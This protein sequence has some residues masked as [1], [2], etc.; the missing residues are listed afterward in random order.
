[1]TTAQRNRDLAEQQRSRDDVVRAAGRL[2]AERGFHGTSMRHLGNELGLLGSSL[3]SHV[4]GKDELLVAVVSRGAALFQALADEVLASELDPP[5]QLRMLVEGHVAIVADNLDEA[6]TILNE[7]RFLPDTA[8]QPIV[9]MRD[10]YEA[11]VRTVIERGV[12]TGDFTA[13][14][15][16]LAA[17]LVLSVL[18]AFERWFRP[19]GTR[20]REQLATDMYRF[21]LGGLR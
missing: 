17:I 15:P 8:R 7:A 5:Q 12:A 13:A 16:G 4:S 1:M 14:D 6:R 2:F 18:N 10:R 9:A 20:T 11:A 19:D 21:V 3:Y